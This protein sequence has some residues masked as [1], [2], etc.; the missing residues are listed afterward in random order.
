MVKFWIIALLLVGNLSMGYSQYNASTIDSLE[1]RLNQ[2]SDKKQRAD[3]LIELTFEKIQARADLSINTIPTELNKGLALC[4]ELN[5]TVGENRMLVNLG[6]WFYYDSKSDSSLYWLNRT[7]PYLKEIKDYK[8]VGHIYFTKGYVNKNLLTNKQSA[9][10]YFDLADSFYQL[11]KQDFFR[12]RAN[13]SKGYTLFD[14]GRYSEA[15][16]SFQNAKALYNQTDNSFWAAHALQHIGMVHQSQKSYEKALKFYTASINQLTALGDSISIIH[17]MGTKVDLLI[18][19]ESYQEA[20]DLLERAIDIRLKQNN[21]DVRSAVTYYIKLGNIYLKRKEYRKTIDFFNEIELPNSP[22]YGATYL[23]YVA[24]AH[25]ELNHQREAR[26]FATLAYQSARKSDHPE[27]LRDAAHISYRVMEKDKNYKLAHEFY[28]EYTLLSDSLYNK[29]EA[30]KIEQIFL[31]QDYKLKKQQLDY[32]NNI[33]LQKAETDKNIRIYLVVIVSLLVLAIF[34]IGRAFLSNKKLY[35]ELLVSRKKVIEM[36]RNLMGKNKSIAKQHKALEKSHKKLQEK[37]VQ[38]LEKNETLLSNQEE[39]KMQTEELKVINENQEK[40]LQQLKRTQKQLI[41]SE[42]MVALGQLVAN[43]AHELNTPLGAILSSNLTAREHF[44]GYYEN[45]MSNMKNWTPVHFTILKKLTQA[46]TSTAAQLS[47]TTLRKNRKLME[48]SLKTHFP[49]D[50]RAIAKQLRSIPYDSVDTELINLLRDDRENALRIIY[51]A[52]QLATLFKT[53]SIIKTASVK[54]SKIVK[55]LKVYAYQSAETRKEEFNIEFGIETALTLSSNQ[56]KKGVQVVRSYAKLPLVS[57][58]P[59]ELNQVWMNLIQNAIYAMDFTGE[60]TISTNIED[61][62]VHV[63]IDDTG[64]GIAEDLQKKIFQPFFTTKPMGEGSGL[65]LS[66][67]KKIIDK[68]HGEIVL[69][70]DVGLGATFHVYL[71]IQDLDNENASE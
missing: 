35:Q 18:L 13:T 50:H 2:V 8:W 32:Q 16:Q 11:S 12:G 51:A 58:Y 20:I 38:L 43:I 25:F 14:L 46:I 60:L 53:Q 39:L 42:K 44:K 30:L 29:S 22:R 10:E 55:A 27:S 41:E 15:L 31:E 64:K 66:I 52:K 37:D 62:Y 40:T 70:S 1:Q 3:L 23:T 48:T 54:S 33:L 71:P 59:D 47:N 63:Q 28:K 7:L 4:K 9:L 57:C 34:F 17:P 68:H 65:G 26:K 69:D 19:Q 36:N 61:D 67:V 24:T 49:E 56:L 6:I 45:S 21:N 5:Y